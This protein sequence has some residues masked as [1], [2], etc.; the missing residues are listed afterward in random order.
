[1]DISTKPLP[2]EWRPENLSN[3]TTQN[4]MVQLQKPQEPQQMAWILKIDIDDIENNVS[5]I[6]KALEDAGIKYNFQIS[7]FESLKNNQVNIKI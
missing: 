4:M 3:I 1:M 5:K 6:I 2:K 7:D